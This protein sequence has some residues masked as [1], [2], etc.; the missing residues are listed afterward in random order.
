[1]S[2]LLEEL[3]M[4]FVSHRLSRLP[5]ILI[6]AII[7]FCSV[8]TFAANEGKLTLPQLNQIISN[9]DRTYSVG[10]IQ[11]AVMAERAIAGA[12]S[13]S[14]DL[15]SWYLQAEQ[16]CG[17]KFF[18]TSCM[19]DIKLV[20]RDK[21]GILQ[22]IKIEAKAWQRKQRIDELDHKLQEKNEQK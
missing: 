22:R 15:Q 13:T 19:N 11:S 12:S 18:V 4:K 9:L 3:R 21:L 14:N 5:M 8:A 6:S 17:D 7:F 16:S 10:V 2:D 20:R 1:M